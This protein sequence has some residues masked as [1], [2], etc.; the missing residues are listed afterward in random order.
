MSLKK[1][2]AICLFAYALWLVPFYRYH[3]VDGANLLIHEAGHMVFLPLGKTMHVMGGT[4]WQLIT[5]LA[6]TLYF[7]LKGKR[8]ESA[9]L[10]LWFGE[11]LMYTAVYAGDAIQMRLPLVG[12][13]LHDWNWL[14]YR[15]G[16]LG[17]CESIAFGLHCA[18]S[19][20]VL[21]S[22]GWTLYVSFLGQEVLVPPQ[23]PTEVTHSAC[24]TAPGPAMRPRLDISQA[25][26]D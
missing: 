19:L 26:E 21:A 5:P 3:F 9:V 8:Y 7:L 10:L 6:A 23:D 12:G 1:L 16:L 22:A 18:A 11:S 2:F 15:F 4:F 14:L 13:G 20:I 25:S 17:Q 24:G